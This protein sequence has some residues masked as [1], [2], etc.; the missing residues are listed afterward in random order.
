MTAAWHIDIEFSVYCVCVC[1]A[2]IYR[3]VRT[4]SS[5]SPN[6]KRL[7]NRIVWFLLDKVGGVIAVY[8]IVVAMYRLTVLRTSHLSFSYFSGCGWTAH[9][10]Q[11]WSHLCQD[12]CCF[13]STVC[14]LYMQNYDIKCVVY[15]DKINVLLFEW[16]T[17]SVLG[18]LEFFFLLTDW[19]KYY[20]C[21]G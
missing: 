2:L 15:K 8:F 20:K 9:R 10:W 13:I 18:K 5:L 14:I 1:F 7:V 19:S 4:K 12:G 21:S 16:P 17:W 6:C 3:R 11:L